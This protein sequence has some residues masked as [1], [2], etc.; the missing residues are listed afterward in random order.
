MFRNPASLHPYSYVHNNP[1]NWTDPT[2]LCV[3]WLD[4]TCRPIWETGSGPNGEDF[5]NYWVTVEQTVNDAIM[6]PAVVAY[7]AT[8]P[9]GQAAIARGAQAVWN[10]FDG[11]LATVAEMF[12]APFNEAY[13]GFMCAD[14]EMIA[15][16]LTGSAITLWGARGAF[17]T[18][19]LKGNE[20]AIRSGVLG[21][22]GKGV[23]ATLDDLSRA[24]QAPAKGTNGLTEAGR[25]LQKHGSRPGSAFSK[26]SGDAEVLNR[27]GQ[28]I[29][30][31]ILTDPGTQFSTRTT[32]RFG[33]V[34]EA[35]APN[36]RGIRWKVDGEWVGFLEP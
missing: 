15:R 14:E 31:D 21:L 16:G 34:I 33:D 19:L 26:P 1:T 3:P 13:L 12:A 25:A 10:D 29:V 11:S 22:T 27:T 6:A 18:N 28:N 24:A 36:G 8:T 5:G 17:R 32:G 9:E 20:G 30:D 35:W 7:N 23:T 4:P 2:G